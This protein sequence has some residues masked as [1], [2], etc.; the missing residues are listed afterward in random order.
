MLSEERRIKILELVQQHGNVHV[1][2]LSERFSTS[3]ATIRSDLNKLYTRGYLK[4]THGGAVRPETIS[5]D[6]S[7]QEKSKMHADEKQRIGAAAAELI[8]DGESIILDSGTTTQQI[9]RHIKSR[10]NLK[11]ITNGVNIAMELLGVPEIQLILLGGAVRPKSFSVVGHFAEEMLDRLSADKLF[12]GADACDMEFGLTTPNLEE[13]QVNQ[14]MVRIAKE[15]I[16]AADSS[17][18]GKRSLARIMSIGEIDKII[19]DED[20]PEATQAELKAKGIELIL[21]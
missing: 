16:L 7:L 3:E 6:R 11:V 2:D 19:T 9:A 14:S 15:K 21:V 10:K 18:F 4:R 5:I 20:L 13:A 12:I 17:K 1:R 8:A